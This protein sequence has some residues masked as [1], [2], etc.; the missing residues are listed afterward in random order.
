MLRIHTFICTHSVHQRQHR[1]DL[2]GAH[3]WLELLDPNHLQS[4]DVD[5]TPGLC[6]LFLA[7]DPFPSLH[8]IES[9][10]NQGTLR[11]LP[12]ISSK[13]PALR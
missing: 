1:V 10:A 4:L 8:T 13:T 12:M 11:Q 7:I 3:H 5:L 6:S 2:M 9:Y